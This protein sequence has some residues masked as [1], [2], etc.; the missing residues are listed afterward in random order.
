M[1][2]QKTHGGDRPWLRAVL[3]L[4]TALLAAAAVALACRWVG[5][6][7]DER[8][9]HVQ[10]FAIVNDDYS[11]VLA[12]PE[13]TGLTQQLPLAAGQ[14]LYGVRFN[15]STY[16]VLYKSGMVMVDVYA[17]DGSLIGQ[18]AGNFLNI[19]NDS[20]T[21]FAFPQPYTAQQDEVLTIQLYNAV[22]W[23]GPLGLWA[24]EGEV[25]GMPLFAGDQPLDATLAVQYMTNDSANWASR[26]AALLA[27]PLALGVGAAV[28]L[29]LW[30]A[31][32][33]AVVAVS[34]L[35]LGSA[36]ALVTPP[37][38]APDEYTHLAAAYEQAS[39]WTGQPAEAQGKLLVRSCDAPYFGT[40]TG[41]VGIFACK[42]TLEQLPATGCDAALT[43]QSEAAAG[44]GGH[45]D[46]TAQTLGIWLARAMGWGFHRMLLAG[47]LANLLLYAALA[48]LAVALAPQRLRGLFGCV[49]LL[50]MPLQLAGSLS[51]DAR[52]IGVALCYTA[53]CLALR[54]R[55][56]R[57]WQLAALA[58]LALLLAPA[59]A[60]YLPLVAL[61]LWV[62]PQHLVLPRSPR[63]LQNGRTVQVLLL[64][65]SAV[66]WALVNA[67]ELLYA[68]RDVHPLLAAAACVLLAVAAALAWFGYRRLCNT[69]L[70]KRRFWQA[71]GVLCVLAVPL[72]VL[73]MAR[74][75][76]N[77][78][79]MQRLELLPN[80]DSPYTY[81][82]GYLCRNLPAAAKLLLRTL[83]EQGALW[84]QGV[85]GTVLGEPIVYKIEVSWLLGVALVLVLLAAALPLAEEPPVLGR[86]SHALAAVLALLVVA[87]TVVVALGWTPINYT[88]LFGLQGRYWLPIVPLLLML[89]R[90]NRTVVL[91][92][93][94]TPA[95]TAALVG[96]DTLL[97]L[98]G[99]GLYATFGVV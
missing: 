59:K 8:V 15:F 11:Q 50:P 67:G 71:L 6:E 35:A 94:P 25:D 65:A 41:E 84:L 47:R 2:E 57:G 91:R 46:Y 3:R 23:D 93:D 92:R 63:A 13:D 74:T 5:Y 89:V 24:S 48:A 34:A 45:N 51:P 75:G 76:Q 52:V 7:L 49:A 66:C 21:A 53:L 82:F 78:T 38:V 64:G 39:R 54:Q 16:D 77:L 9:G 20:F 62:P 69:P 32:Q 1:A 73:A 55:A 26:G 14:T 98:Q 96:L 97:L 79:P 36:F 68:A 37:L 80:G 33:A 18:C 44:Q 88:T 27:W 60:V 70:R 99:Y 81:S 58:V 43:T 31:P 40:R 42:Q 19:H 56:A 61:C 17:Q 28:L 4:A 12:L 29:L 22:P 83:P 30:H 95:L 85:L 10:Q 72:A 90:G 87:L 86:R